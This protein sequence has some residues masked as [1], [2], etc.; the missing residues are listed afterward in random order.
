[1]LLRIPITTST[2]NTMRSD[3]GSTFGSILY[4]RNKYISQN[5]RNNLK[6]VK[7]HN[8]VIAKRK[9]K[10]STVYP[11]V[12]LFG[13]CDITLSLNP[14]SSTS[15]LLSLKNC[16]SILSSISVINRFCLSN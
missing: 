6:T 8:K 5:T 13:K 16:F 9:V 3:L 10:S 1:M 12:E 15:F 14:L 2:I 7:Y 4:K 11:S